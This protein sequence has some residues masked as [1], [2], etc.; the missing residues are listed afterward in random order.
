MRWDGLQSDNVEDR[1]GQGFGGP[2]AIGGGGLGV[3]AIVIIGMLF[4]ADPRQ[5]M[6]QVG[7]GGQQVQQQQQPGGAPPAGDK[8]A[9]FAS[10]VLKSTEVVWTAEFQQR[11]Q[12]YEDPRLVLYDQMTSTGCGTGESAMGPFYCP[13][14]HRVYLDLSFFRELDSRFGAPG[15]FARA[16]V[17]AHEVGHHV[18]T[19]M[20]VSDK[21]H[22]LQEQRGGVEAKRLS[23][24]LELQA[25]CLAGVWAN[26]ADKRERIVEPGDIDEAL[27]AA[28][29]VG[30]DTLQRASG[31]AVTP[32]AFTHGSSE[33]RQRWFRTGFSS[34]QMD[35]CDTF[36]P[37]NAQL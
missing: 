15:D 8:Q 9:A 21:V 27:R 17:I 37:S 34:G 7:G 1:R 30:D 2:I 28:T 24:R 33:Q 23:V 19:L 10:A 32:D 11:G 29:S 25:D 4:G 35:S 5:I 3:L 12:T 14:D 13:N 6:D 18:Q 31:R 16:Y 36:S 20:G 22:Q 26:Q